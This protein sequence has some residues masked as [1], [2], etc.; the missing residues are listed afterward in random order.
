VIYNR[1]ERR[2]DN[3]KIL[4]EVDFNNQPI[5]AHQHILN[6]ARL[7]AIALSIYLAS[8]KMS[9]P[10]DLPGTP[11]SLRL[12]VLD[13][14]VIG[15]D[16]ANRLPLLNILQNEFQD[17][18]IILTTYDKV[19][20]DMV[21]MRNP[22][23]GYQEIFITPSLIPVH[24]TNVGYLA[25]ARMHLENNDDHAA[26]VYTRVEFERKLKKFCEK[27]RVKLQYKQPPD[28]PDSGDMLDSLENHLKANA[29]WSTPKWQEHY[30]PMFQGLRAVRKVVLNPLSHS[31]LVTIVKVEIKDAI[32]AVDSFQLL[33]PSV[34]R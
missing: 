29:M 14:V 34:N 3:N 9:V 1:D 27:E 17:W 24:K 2:L 33:K 23:W 13:D 16:L 22:N 20:F 28:S 11:D 31:Q 10:P 5:P 15:L 19:W 26:A 4:L 30:P 18:Q 7:S 21:R 6:E 32:D 12:L 25:K 8:A